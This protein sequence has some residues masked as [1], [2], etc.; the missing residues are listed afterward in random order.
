MRRI[1]NGQS[2][3]I[4][5]RPRS[6]HSN[7]AA[8]HIS[9][10]KNILRLQG[11]SAIAYTVLGAALIAGCTSPN[12]DREVESAQSTPVSAQ[13]ML[14]ILT[15]LL[16]DG[17]LSQQEGTGLT[18]EAPTANAEL[19][20]EASGRSAKVKLSLFRWGLPIP[21]LFLQCPD[22]AYAPYSQCTKSDLPDG[23]QITVDQSPAKNSNPTGPQVITVQ[24]TYKDGGQILVTQ[25]GTKNERIGKSGRNSL[26]LTSD[27]I[28]NVAKA[29]E[30]KPILAEFPKP[31]DVEQP[32]STARM[33]GEEIGRTITS[34]L[35]T[36]I[37]A[38]EPSGSD[39]FGHVTIDD[40]N[41]KS[42]IAVN[43]QQWE[44]GDP[45]MRKVFAGADI[46]P[47]QTRI[48]ITK[49]P[50]PDGGKGAVVWSVDTLKKDGARVRVMALNAKAY[51]LP[52]SRS[53]PALTIEQLKTIAL[54]KQ[55]QDAAELD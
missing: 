20:F 44:P 10:E 7:Q 1:F 40:G 6:R 52:A 42:L 8:P 11:I 54:D 28:S 53:I 5:G 35:P 30:W 34:L 25:A 31:P 49:E 12:A 18:G 39:G 37:E 21:S 24:L 3:P 23:A 33:T 9:G 51:T 47:D 26:P 13:Q 16:P 27:Q 48:K 50:S 17:T 55:W 43:V 46:L 38:T 15:S 32:K 2:T 22:T 36:G 19:S 29:I 14:N 45:R 4:S 41:G